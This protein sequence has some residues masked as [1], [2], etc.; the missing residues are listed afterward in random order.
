MADIQVRIK[1][2]AGV[3][4]DQ[5]N[6]VAFN[7][8]TN[9][10]S[11]AVGS[12]TTKNDGQNLISWGQITAYKNGEVQPCI[13]LEDG[14]VGGANSTL[15]SQGGYNGFVFGVV[16][17]NKM[18]S[19]EIT[20]EGSN[21]DSVTF[22]G[23]K[24][25]NQ[26]PTR[27]IVNGEYIYSDDA[28]WTIV[29]P[30]SSATQTI[31]FDMWNRANYNA[32]F[33]HIGVFVNE[34]VLDK[35]Q[36]KEIETLSQS[37][38]ESGDIKYGITYS[39]G[40][41]SVID[42]N[43]EIKDY[44]SDNIISS[45]NL[46]VSIYANDKIVQHQLS[47][48]IDYDINSKTFSANLTSIKN[49]QIKTQGLSYLIENENI[50][51]YSST[52]GI[53]LKEILVKYVFDN[54]DIDEMLQEK[55]FIHDTN[56]EVSIDFYLSTIKTNY[57][58]VLNKSKQD[59]LNDVCSVA[60]LHFVRTG[61][62]NYKFISGR[63]IY[64][65]DI[66]P[67]IINKGNI[68]SKVST[69]VVVKNKY[70]KIKISQPEIIHNFTTIYSK[71]FTIRDY[72]DSEYTTA[73]M[74][75]LDAQNIIPGVDDTRRWITYIDSIKYSKDNLFILDSSTNWAMNFVVQQNS[76][77]ISAKNKQGMLVFTN[78]EADNFSPP[79]ISNGQI[80][81]LESDSNHNNNKPYVL[82]FTIDADPY[83]IPSSPG[84]RY[85]YDSVAVNIYSHKYDIN[86]QDYVY[87]DGEN[88]LQVAE[89]ALLHN[90]TFTNYS[91]NIKN[92]PTIFAENT[93]NDYKNGVRTATLSVGCLNYY[94]SQGSLAKDWNQGDMIQVGEF[95]KFDGDNSVWIVTGRNFRK[96]G[97]PMIDL[98][99]KEAKIINSNL[100]TRFYKNNEVTIPN[101]DTSFYK[102]YSFNNETKKFEYEN[103]ISDFS[104]V[105]SGDLI[106][107]KFSDTY[108]VQYIILKTFGYTNSYYGFLANILDVRVKQQ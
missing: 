84:L 64:G 108:C 55:T 97:V 73:Y 105:Q 89:N 35:R 15:S 51:D 100:T 87:G 48:N 74:Q 65:S 104:E 90:N 72:G 34:L 37:T 17:E 95:V 58:Y 59:I 63:P 31:T 5:I 43:G 27:A 69:D 106:V 68:F 75:G 2:N 14:Y 9:N 7:Q 82:G 25:A 10:V 32:C 12:K 3:D 60:Q 50:S 29:F 8:E 80:C 70:N 16:P 54:N 86:S 6:S 22:Y 18:Y 92:M 94:D 102:S 81:L 76:D 62:G 39:R 30:S 67:I 83:P 79:L 52:G 85:M 101:N 49:S 20:L 1:L 66:N 57:F 91:G 42:I 11:K 26:F 93:L 38:P 44:I 28:E 53:S 40:N 103:A 56:E 78:E 61:D 107:K 19:V 47:E 71:D 23:D 98:E 96:S 13:S 41:I 24:N 36:I 77:N 45:D 88:E 33:T 99:L 21:I 46:E 4:G